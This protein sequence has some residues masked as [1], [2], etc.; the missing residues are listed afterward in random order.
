MPGFAPKAVHALSHLTFTHF[1]EEYVST[2][3]SDI[4]ALGHRLEPKYD[5]KT[6]AVNQF[7]VS[8]C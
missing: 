4:R 1:N 3:T 2:G 8:T 6:Q 5:F 7:N